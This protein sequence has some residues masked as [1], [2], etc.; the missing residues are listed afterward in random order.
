VERAREEHSDVFGPFD[1]SAA[2]R[3]D[4][5]AITLAVVWGLSVAEVGFAVARGH[6]FGPDRGLALAFAIGCPL[7]AGSRLVELA[8]GWMGRKRG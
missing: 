8:K 2:P 1:S 3:F 7:V 4:P 6:A 5:E